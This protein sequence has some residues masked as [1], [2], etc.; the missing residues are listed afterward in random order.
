V[1]LAARLEAHT[2]VAQRE[3]LVDAATRA[4]AGDQFEFEPLG[5]VPFKGKTNAVEVFS[6]ATG[7]HR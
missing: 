3:I 6:V 5:P 1:N 2:R 4:A 7:T